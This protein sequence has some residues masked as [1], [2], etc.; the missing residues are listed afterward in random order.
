[1]SL[2]QPPQALSAAGCKKAIGNSFLQVIFN[3]H[4]NRLQEALLLPLFF[5]QVREDPAIDDE[6]V[7]RFAKTHTQSSL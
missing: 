4:T 7:C 2:L 6:V 5:A 3:M 1:M